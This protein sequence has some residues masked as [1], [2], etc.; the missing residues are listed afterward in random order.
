MD[1]WR[2][3]K[4]KLRFSERLSA[5]TSFKIGGRAS[6][7]FEPKDVKDLKRCLQGLKKY[8]IPYFLIGNGTNLLI[9]D[10]GFD[11]MVIKLCSPAFKRISRKGNI[12]TVASG[13]SIQS[14][15]KYLSRTRLSGYEF[16]A[17]IPGTIAGA[18]AMNAGTIIEGKKKNIGDI[19]YKLKVLNKRGEIKDL[20]KRECGFAYRKSSLD[21]YIVLKAE[22][23]LSKVNVVT[24][25]RINSLLLYRKEHQDYSKPNAGC[26][27]KNPSRHVSAGKLIEDCG[28]KGLRYGGA[29]I[30]NKHAN[31][32]LN[33]NRATA[34]DV[35]KLINIAKRRVKNRFGV[36]LKEEIKIVS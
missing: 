33:F 21:K 2:A 10:C 1:L 26:I 14:L 4:G 36:T 28:L 19:A 24:K 32:I 8:K 34:N 27:F 11:G 35:I 20:S 16:L 30:S 18:L 31:F 25:N 23:K 13:A 22:L 6:V 17:G 7:L 29:M 12:I 3:L 5:H 9:K 15:L